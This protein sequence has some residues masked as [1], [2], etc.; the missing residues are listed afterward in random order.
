MFGNV[1]GRTLFGDPLAGIERAIKKAKQ[2]R[3]VREAIVS[4]IEKDSNRALKSHR[5]TY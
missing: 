5:P 1:C 2:T 3:V 4:C